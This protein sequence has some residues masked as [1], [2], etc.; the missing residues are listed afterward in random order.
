L[1]AFE[2]PA[3]CGVLACAVTAC[4]AF[5]SWLATVTWLT[6]PTPLMRGLNEIKLPFPPQVS[7]TAGVSFARGRK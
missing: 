5:G 6:C 7:V 2:A 3:I 1:S 4:A